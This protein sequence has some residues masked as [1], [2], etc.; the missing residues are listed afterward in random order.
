MSKE[1]VEKG[2]WWIYR[3]CFSFLV[4][5]WL[6]SRPGLCSAFACRLRF[7]HSPSH[8]IIGDSAG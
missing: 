8:Y 5:L 3:V 7:S 2:L 6:I 1:R 4:A